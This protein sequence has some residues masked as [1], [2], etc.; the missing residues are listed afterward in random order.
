M[1]AAADIFSLNSPTVVAVDIAGNVS[2]FTSTEG[3]R[4]MRSM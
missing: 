4:I 1:T 2:L 3:E